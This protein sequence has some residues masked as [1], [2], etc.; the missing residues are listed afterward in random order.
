MSRKYEKPRI[1]SERVFSLASQACD[2]DCPSPGVCAS[3]ITY[4]A[5]YP[6]SWKVKDITCGII[7]IPPVYKS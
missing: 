6:F 2:V 3:E 4:E 1:T 5:C 7:P